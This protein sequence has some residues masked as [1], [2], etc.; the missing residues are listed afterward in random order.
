MSHYC[1]SIGLGPSLLLPSLLLCAA[2]GDSS[3]PD[4]G[5]SVTPDET[6]TAETTSNSGD[7]T[8]EESATSTSL[9]ETS[10]A[11]SS[12]ASTATPPPLNASSDT[13]PNATLNTSTESTPS[14]DT[15]T[16]S[17]AS[18]PSTADDNDTSV[19]A[20]VPSSC[21]APVYLACGD[22]LAHDTR[23]QGRADEW[24]LYSCSAQG[25]WG[26][27]TIYEFTVSSNCGVEVRL[28]AVDIDLNLFVIKEC[29]SIQAEWCN[30]TAL[31]DGV[32]TVNFVATAGH[33]YTVAV[34]GLEGV[35]GPYTLEVDCT[36][37]TDEATAA[38][39]SVTSP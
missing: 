23:V 12:N 3:K 11:S 38:D 37:D 34:D 15:A 26:R 17:D 20:A 30:T 21:E 35:A 10:G 24:N 33:A 13:E 5:T 6:D 19:D 4:V 27:E 39:A 18:V 22:R 7:A 8:V 14:L 2:C 9:G 29:E 31:P 32:A 25:Y 16:L 1:S 36:C 28:S